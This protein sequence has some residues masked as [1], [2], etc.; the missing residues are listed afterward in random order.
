LVSK[1]GDSLDLLSPIMLAALLAQRIAGPL[2]AILCRRFKG[3]RWSQVLM[4]PMIL[5]GVLLV[6][7]G[8]AG[9][10]WPAPSGVKKI[11]LPIYVEKEPSPVALI[12]VGSIRMDFQTQGFF[13]IGLL[14]LLV[15]ED[16]AIEITRPASAAAGLAGIDHW[17]SGHKAGRAMELRRVRIQVNG[18]RTN[19]LEAAVA[20]LDDGGQWQL[21][22]GV[23][24]RSPGGEHADRRARLQCT[25]AQAGLIQW[26]GQR[27][28]NHLFAAAVP[29]SSLVRQPLPPKSP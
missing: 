12:E 3:A 19:T 7:D 29:P 4:F 22:S 1:A 26:I 23:K 5:A 11:L 18:P 20:R 13:R 16:V 9:Q 15:F 14:P 8:N 25:G 24:F 27:E 17:L 21:S 10:R 6:P 28:T 2:L